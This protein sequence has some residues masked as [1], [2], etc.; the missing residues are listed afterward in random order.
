MQ[1]LCFSWLGGE[2]RR[3]DSCAFRIGQRNGWDADESGYSEGLGG[4]TAR[5]CPLVPG[6]TEL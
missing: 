6:R 5:V 2:P 3:E 4:R 1:A